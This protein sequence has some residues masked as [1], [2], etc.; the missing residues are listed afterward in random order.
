MMEETRWFIYVRAFPL[1][2]S[3]VCPLACKRTS[4]FFSIVKCPQLPSLAA[5]AFLPLC[6]P[7]SCG[8]APVNLF[9]LPKEMFDSE[10]RSGVCRSFCPGRSQERPT[11]SARGT[12]SVKAQPI[13][14]GRSAL[15]FSRY[16]VLSVLLYSVRN[17]L[18]LQRHLYS[19][20]VHY[21]GSMAVVESVFLDNAS[22]L[23]S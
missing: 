18:S 10:P 12:S 23:F 9:P 20:V 6:A 15:C 1:C 5:R 16:L 13:A 3:T 21:W 17:K 4:P 2:P 7:S 8:S 11:E 22:G 19:D 14:N